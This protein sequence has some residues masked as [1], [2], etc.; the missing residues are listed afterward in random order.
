MSENA[1]PPQVVKPE[2]LKEL[3]AVASNFYYPCKKCEQDRYHKVITHPTKTSAKLECE[4]CHAKQTFKLGKKKTAATGGRKRKKTP[5]PAEMW[6]ELK[7][8]VDIAN[9]EPY[10]MKKRFSAETAID[11]PKFGLGVVTESTGISIQVAFE[12]G[13]KSLVHNRTT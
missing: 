4:V 2:D 9:P 11:H 10:N 5:T 12:D 6:V 1:A 13:V 7:Q 3:P 8:N